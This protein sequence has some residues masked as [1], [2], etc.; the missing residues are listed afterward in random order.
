[1]AVILRILFDLFCVYR[2]FVYLIHLTSGIIIEA[3]FAFLARIAMTVDSVSTIPTVVDLYLTSQSSHSRVS[4]TVCFRYLR[5]HDLFIYHHSIVMKWFGFPHMLKASVRLYDP[6]IIR[7]SVSLAVPLTNITLDLLKKNGSC[8]GY[9]LGYN[10]TLLVFVILGYKVVSVNGYPYPLAVCV[11]LPVSSL[12]S[13][14]FT[15][16]TI[17]IEKDQLQ[18]LHEVQRTVLVPLCQLYM[19][20]PCI[21]QDEK[22]IV[23]TPGKIWIFQTHQFLPYEMVESLRNKYSSVCY[24]YPS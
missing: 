18:S 2:S 17:I 12:A 3:I 9:K 8:I 22:R 6:T 16:H 11:H 1:M 24:C 21:Y 20:M 14:S 23:L 4:M 7:S 19:N 5:M 10:R 13:Q 15:Y